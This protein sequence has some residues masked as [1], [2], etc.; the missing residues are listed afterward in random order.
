M[1]NT[2]LK[3]RKDIGLADLWLYGTKLMQSKVIIFSIWFHPPLEAYKYQ[4]SMKGR[5][6]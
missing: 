3:N 5:R 6:R 2:K 1:I 4:F